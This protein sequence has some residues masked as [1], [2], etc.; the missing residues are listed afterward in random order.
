MSTKRTAIF[1]GSGPLPRANRHPQCDLL[2]RIGRVP[3]E[4]LQALVLLARPADD[5]PL[6]ALEPWP[7]AVAVDEDPAPA[8]DVGQEER[9]LL[10]LL[11]GDQLDAT[12]TRLLKCTDELGASPMIVAAET[13]EH[14]QVTVRLLRAA[15]D[16]PEEGRQANVRMLAQRFE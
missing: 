14:V 10:C 3:G 7:V 6:A 2:E 15:G 16:A 9:G 12:P 4:A 11:Q 8:Q 1:R 13:D 5:L